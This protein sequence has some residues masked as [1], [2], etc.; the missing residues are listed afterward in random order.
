M[1]TRDNDPLHAAINAGLASIV[2]ALAA[3]P[4]WYQDWMKLGPE[5]SEEERLAV[6]QAVRDSGCLPPDAGFHLVFWQIDAMASMEAETSLRDLDNRM[7]AIE[8]AYELE[9]GAIWP[10]E[11]A[12]PEYAKLL[13]QSHDDWDRIF[14]AKLEAFGEQE[15]ADLYRADR[16]EFHRRGEVGRQYF[17]GRGNPAWLEDL[18]EAVVENMTDTGGPGTSGYRCREEEGFWEVAIYP[19]PVEL[20]GGAEDGEIVAPRILVGPGGTAVAVRAGGRFL[21]GRPR[22]E[23]Q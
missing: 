1:N 13:E 12:P 6:Y 10:P 21:L 18:V 15:I 22:P 23:R 7:K 3:K 4:A 8:D 5:S 16:E 11:E 19:K 14:L 20:V 9:A 2:Q 17:H